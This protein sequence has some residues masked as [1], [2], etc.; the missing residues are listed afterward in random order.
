MLEQP[1]ISTGCSSIYFIDSPP[2][3]KTASYATSGPYPAQGSTC[4]T[5][6][7]SCCSITH[8]VLP[9]LPLTRGA[10]DLPRGSKYL[11]QVFLLTYFAYFPSKGITW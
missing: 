1:L 6:G 9:T 7:T 4:V 8:Q 3:L 10:E 11:K 5:Y 2:F